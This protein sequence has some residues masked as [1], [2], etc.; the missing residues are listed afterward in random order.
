MPEARPQQAVRALFGMKV[1]ALLLCFASVL[2][3]QSVQELVTMGDALD[4]KNQNSDAL[5]LYVKADAIKPNNAE[6]LRRLSKQY[7]QLMLDASSSSAKADLG[8]KALD[9]AKRAVAADPNNSQAHLALAIVYGRLALDESARRKIELSRLIKQEAETAARLDP[10]NDLAWYV[11]GRWNYEIANFNPVLKA[12]AQTIYGKLPDASMEKAV[13]CFQ[14]A[15]ALQPRRA[16]H[17]LELARAYLAL[18]ETQKARQ[19][20]KTGLALP[21]T[22]KDDDDNKE[23]A[24]ATLSQL[25]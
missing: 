9:A 4:E 18:G 14:R 19:E 22:D 11:L 7:A 10:G 24:R 12:L 8:G 16:I 21:S 5:A 15:I 6:I 1:L 25:N 20:L 23:R 17:H 2:K 3:A 13:E